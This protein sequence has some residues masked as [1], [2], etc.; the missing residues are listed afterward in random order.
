MASYSRVLTCLRV[1]WAQWLPNVRQIGLSGPLTLGTNGALGCGSPSHMATI[2]T[3]VVLPSMQ[4]SRRLHFA[5]WSPCKLVLQ[6]RQAHVLTQFPPGSG[7]GVVRLVTRFRRVARAGLRLPACWW[8]TWWWEISFL[9]DWTRVTEMS[10]TGAVARTYSSCS[11][12]S[13]LLLLQCNKSFPQLS[14]NSWNNSNITSDLRRS[15]FPVS[16]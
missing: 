15:V 16:A 6:E 10:S 14:K 2:A 4:P 11:C 12:K 9:T 3:H 5:A 1:T 7:L 13:L 8:G